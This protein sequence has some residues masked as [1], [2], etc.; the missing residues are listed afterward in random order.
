MSLNVALSDA[1]LGTSLGLQVSQGRP[2][3]QCLSRSFL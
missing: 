2:G 3:M 1:C